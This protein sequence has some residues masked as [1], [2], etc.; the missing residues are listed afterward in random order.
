MRKSETDAAIP[1]DVLLY[2]EQVRSVCGEREAE[3]AACTTNAQLKELLYGSQEI[4]EFEEDPDTGEFVEV[5]TANPNVATAWPE[6][7]Q[8]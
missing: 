8:G 6:Q 5:R 2:R 1:A 3:I 4:V 7:P